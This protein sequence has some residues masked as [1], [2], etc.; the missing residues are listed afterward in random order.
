MA[1][2]VGE[3]VIVTI[4]DR[5]QVGT[6]IDRY[7]LKK[8]VVYDVLL[9]NRSAL[10]QLNTAVS[11]N[12]YI[13]RILTAKLCQQETPLVESTVPYKDL[14]EQDLLPICKC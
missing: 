5:H 4:E 9:E 8:Q 11:K 12:T 7:P 3:S 2:R 10:I 6:V 14:L 1:Y 13:N